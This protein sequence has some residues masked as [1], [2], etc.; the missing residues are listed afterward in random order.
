MIIDFEHRNHS[1]CET[2]IVSNLLNFYGFRLSEP[3]IFGISAGF[4]FVYLPFFI[5]ERGVPLVG[6]RTFPGTIVNNAF[7]KL[8]IEIIT[9]HYS[10]QQKDKAMADMDELLAAGIPVCNKVGMFH[11]SYMP[12]VMRE[13]WNIHHFCVIGREGDEYTVSEP[14]YGIKKISYENLKKVRFSEGKIKPRGKMYW[15]K[16]KP[17]ALPDLRQLIV[18]GIKRTCRNMVGIYPGSL[19]SYYGTRGIVKLSKFV[20]KLDKKLGEKAPVF[21]AKMIRYLEELSTGGAGFRFIYSAFLFEAADILNKPELKD[22]SI[23]MNNIGNL[24]R[25]FAIEGG[26][27]LKNRNN[28]TYEE[29]ADKLL[30]IAKAEKIF[31]V[32]LRKYVKNLN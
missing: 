3:M 19:A 27:K 24:W 21:L 8:G 2:G 26:R 29:L 30:M 32:A 16:E 1:H 15:V 9:K 5:G 4:L 7:K 25:D 10:N 23:E 22:F 12:R 11:L 31:F 28:I 13:H 6:F 14:L 18:Y 20:S 17:V